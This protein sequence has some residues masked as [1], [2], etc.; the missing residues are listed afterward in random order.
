MDAAV[1]TPHRSIIPTADIHAA[2][3]ESEIWTE[4][5]K[6][7]DPAF[8]RSYVVLYPGSS[9]LFFR[10]FGRDNEVL[11]S[12]YSFPSLCL[13]IHL[14]LL[15]SSV[16]LFVAY[17]IPQW[18]AVYVS[19][20]SLSLSLLSTLSENGGGAVTNKT[21][22]DQETTEED[23]NEFALLS[24][25]LSCFVCVVRTPERNQTMSSLPPPPPGSSA[26]LSL[27]PTQAHSWNT[28]AEAKGDGVYVHPNHLLPSCHSF[29]T[30]SPSCVL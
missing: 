29:P 7:E 20:Q 30:F 28:C 23:R 26:L 19:E 27:E 15:I 22:H 24:G 11:S 21:R 17:F 12:S 10:L 9:F 8:F 6:D 5:R 2:K 14:Y 18:D 13:F 1:Y 25:R 16:Y 3:K 4:G